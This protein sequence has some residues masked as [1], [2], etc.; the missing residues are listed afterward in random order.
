MNK[1]ERKVVQV[2]KYLWD[3]MKVEA[4]KK[5]ITVTQVMRT[6]L[7]STMDPVVVNAAMHGNV[8]ST[9]GNNKSTASTDKVYNKLTNEDE[10]LAEF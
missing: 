1:L 2:P 6:K 5:C 8:P 4:D 3:I 10:E 9:Q 7:E